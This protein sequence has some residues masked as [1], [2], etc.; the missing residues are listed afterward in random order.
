[1]QWLHLL[2]VWFGGNRKKKQRRYNGRR[3]SMEQLPP[4]EMMAVSPIGW[5]D[6]VSPSGLVSGWAV[7][8]DTPNRSI[9]IQVRVDGAIATTILADGSRP[10]VN[11]ALVIG[12]AH[13]F[14]WQLPNRYQDGERHLVEVYGLDNKT[15]V[16]SPLSGRIRYTNV[17]PT[18]SL[19]GITPDGVVTG[20]AADLSTPNPSIA[21]KIYVDG[22][23]VAQVDAVDG[24]PDV[25][26]ALGIGGAH[27]FHWQLPAQYRDGKAHVVEAFGIDSQEGRRGA[28][29]GSGKSYANAAPIGRLDSVSA[30]GMVSGWAVDHSN[31]DRSI[32]VHIY[33]DGKFV[34]QVE[35]ADARPDVNQALGIVGAHG[36]HWQLPDSYRDGKSHV[37]SVYGIDLQ[38]VNNA[39]LSGSNKTFLKEPVKARDNSPPTTISA[40][41]VTS[42]SNVKTGLQLVVLGNWSNASVTNLANTLV[43]PGSPAAIE[44][45]FTTLFRGLGAGGGDLNIA[46]TSY[47]NIR[48]LLQKLQAAGKT[49]TITVNFGF[50]EAQDVTDAQSGAYK[51]ALRSQIRSFQGFL[52]TTARFNG[53]KT[54]IRDLKNVKFVVSPSLEDEYTNTEFERAVVFIARGLGNDLTRVTFRRNSTDAAQLAA[55]L[56][57]QTVNLGGTLGNRTLKVSREYHGPLANVGDFEVYSNDGQFVFSNVDLAGAKSKERNSIQ[58]EKADSGQNAAGGP[59]GN[60]KPTMTQFLNEVDTTFANSTKQR[61]VLFW[62]PAYNLYPT[63]PSTNGADF[64]YEMNKAN[65]PLN[66]RT[67]GAGKA[68]KFNAL[69]QQ[70][71]R[72]L[73]GI[74]LV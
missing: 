34:A 43:E 37:V 66:G 27:G 9:S 69:E 68:A 20:W 26:Q 49:V 45:S 11:Q 67:D 40:P 71:V 48:I 7:D 33:V 13:G 41:A 28:L 24:R 57:R 52:N 16:A 54:A 22:Q 74:P 15:N 50:H 29:H 44:I 17:A 18:G 12:G 31:S 59:F 55:T 1:M 53:V 39:Q 70:L 60:T 42:N 19:D 61:T 36:F 23:F 72:A 64:S 21:V 5:L 6:A 65:A 3:L 73:L 58:D 51:A 63:I 46:Q 62:R 25:N 30:D 38:G 32:P 4:R 35:A 47:R 10:D 56:T 2:G 8:Q 14:Q